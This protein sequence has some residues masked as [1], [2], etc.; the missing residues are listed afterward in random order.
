MKLSVTIDAPDDSD[1]NSKANPDFNDP[2]ISEVLE[3]YLREIFPASKKYD[4][5]EVSLTFM[6]PEEIRALNRDYRDVDEATDVLS[7][8]MID[9]TAG[10]PEGMPLMLGDIVICPEEVSRLHPELS[11]REA[12]CLMVAHS[13]LHLL[14]YDHDTEEKES[15]MWTK[16][17]E[18]SRRLLEVLD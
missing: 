5:A 10:M 13:F 15:A 9:E 12:M 17:D 1:G 3:E 16:Q 7:F 11:E 18:I 2:R 8:P 4:A 14:G 6:P